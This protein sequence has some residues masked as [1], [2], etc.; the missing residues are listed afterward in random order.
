MWSITVVDTPGG[1]RIA[2]DELTEKPWMMD[3]AT[4]P[5]DIIKMFESLGF[6][7]EK[8]SVRVLNP[9]HDNPQMWNIDYDPG[10]DSNAVRLI[11]ER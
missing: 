11:L 1:W 2:P 8:H 9:D 4:H 3:I 10:A 6:T 5:Q 7:V